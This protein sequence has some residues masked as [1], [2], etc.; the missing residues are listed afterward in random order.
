M[1]YIPCGHG[2]TYQ[3]LKIDWIKKYGIV[4]IWRDYCKESGFFLY[5][6]KTT[7]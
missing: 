5:Q 7:I 2:K 4:K 6:D 1:I 3:D